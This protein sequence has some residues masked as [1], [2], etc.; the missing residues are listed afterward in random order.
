[1]TAREMQSD[2]LWYALPAKYGRHRLDSSVRFVH[3]RTIWN[4][5]NILLDYLVGED[6]NR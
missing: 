3:F 4:Y 1:M 2:R 6:E 5:T